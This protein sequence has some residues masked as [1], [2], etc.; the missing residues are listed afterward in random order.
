[1]SMRYASRIDVNQVQIVRELRDLGFDV[2]IVSREKKM[3]DIVV[4]G[5]PVWSRRSC[6][7]RV[8][9]KADDKAPLTP[10]EVEYWEKQRNRDNL[11][12]A[13]CTDDILRWFGRTS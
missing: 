10:F 8:E 6:A 9:I 7:V 1:M 11:I 12:R 2:D 5:T 4:S 13:H 3:Y